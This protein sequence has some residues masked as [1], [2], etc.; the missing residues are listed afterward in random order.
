MKKNSDPVILH[1]YSQDWMQPG[2]VLEHGRDIFMHPDFAYRYFF[3]N[4]SFSVAWELSA[5]LLKQRAF[6]ELR[7]YHLL[8]TN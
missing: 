7:F 8:M 5:Q 2:Q 1:L 4:F 6:P 3:Q